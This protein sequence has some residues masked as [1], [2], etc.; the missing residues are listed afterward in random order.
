MPTSRV[1]CVFTATK[2]NAGPTNMNFWQATVHI[3]YV[4]SAGSGDTY[5]YFTKKYLEEHKGN[6]GSGDVCSVEK[7]LYVKIVRKTIDLE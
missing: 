2:W 7:Y 5:E 1:Q 6:S 4:L 3:Q